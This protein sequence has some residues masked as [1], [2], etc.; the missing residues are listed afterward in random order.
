VPPRRPTR[1][2]SSPAAVRGDGRVVCPTTTSHTTAGRS[3]R[4]CPR[5]P[6]P[7]GCRP[8]GR[9]APGP[10]G[11]SERALPARAPPGPPPSGD[12]PR[13]H[14]AGGP[15][16]RGFGA[17]PGVR[18]RVCAARA[19]LDAPRRA[20]PLTAGVGPDAP[21]QGRHASVTALGV[22]A[23]TYT[24]PRPAGAQR[25]PK[26]ITTPPRAG[27]VGTPRWRPGPGPMRT[28]QALADH[29]GPSGTG[30]RPGWCIRYSPGVEQVPEAHIVDD[31]GQH[32]DRRHACDAHRGHAGLLPCLTARAR[33]L[34]GRIHDGFADS[35][36]SMSDYDPVMSNI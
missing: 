36:C 7:A 27:G 35:T 4:D 31:R 20:T 32:P 22:R 30:C 33:G 1:R 14:T 23:I 19:G 2:T 10:A 17:S 18:G 11:G 13:A 3:A 24:A 28:A 5:P 25:R 34:P 16:G 29:P 6:G 12:P 21:G 8:P 9:R 26:A 15:L